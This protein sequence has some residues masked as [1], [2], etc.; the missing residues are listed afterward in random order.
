MKA[1]TTGR[2]IE[3]T[4][5]FAPARPLDASKG[6]RRLVQQI[7]ESQRSLRSAWRG[8]EQSFHLLEAEPDGSPV[9]LFAM[10]ARWIDAAARLNEI[11]ARLVET[12]AQM[13]RK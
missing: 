2:V 3:A 11:S 4:A 8:I 9:L 7:G 1:E 12:S 13:V 5:R 6:L 10:T